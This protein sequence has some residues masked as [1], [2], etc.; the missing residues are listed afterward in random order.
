MQRKCEKNHQRIYE[1]KEI[2]TTNIYHR[3]HEEMFTRNYEGIN[4]KNDDGNHCKIY[5][6]IALAV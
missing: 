4:E 5:E 6:K 3:I 2:S 1:Q